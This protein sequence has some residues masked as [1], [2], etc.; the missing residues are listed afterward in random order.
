[1]LNKPNINKNIG[2]Q[3][4]RAFLCFWVLLN[5]CFNAHNIKLR[6]YLFK[7][8]LHV[9]CFILTSFYFSYKTITSRDIIK[10]KKRFER[11]LIPYLVF[12]LIILILNN[13]FNFFLS[14]GIFGRYLN[15]NDL[16]YQYIFGRRFNP[17]FWFQLYLI[18]STLLFII[19]SFLFKQKFSLVIINIY[20]IAYFLQYSNINLKFFSKFTPSVKL[21][22]GVFVEMLPISVTGLLIAY[23]NVFKL[24][25]NRI[26]SIYFSF[27]SLLF[28]II[29][30]LFSILDGVSFSGI[31]LN[32]GSIYLFVIFYL[33]PINYFRSITFTK[34]ILI[35]T[36]YTQGIYCMHMILKVALNRK[37]D[38]IKNGSFIGCI[39]IY[40]FCYI[41]SFLGHKL[42]KKTKLIYLFV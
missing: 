38:F 17:V 2:I 22:V 23:F 42:T 18:W 5:H 31:V 39:L 35:F 16:F 19:I 11:I 6:N 24:I 27:I 28:I 21:S 36:N 40:I 41:I 8:R 4:L 7:Y 29:Y 25:N 26:F 33:I 20:F 12:P 15:L 37:I 34:Y 10:I 32:I 1:M 30:D 3:I 14:I 13:L 9:P